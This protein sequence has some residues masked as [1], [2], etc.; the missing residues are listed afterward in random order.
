[1]A[2]MIRDV[3]IRSELSSRACRHRDY[4]SE[5]R[6]MAALAQEMA[7]NP[8][9]MLQKLAETALELC[10]AET[11]GV[12]LLETEEG[13]ELFRWES[14]AGMCAKFR[15]N[16]M[17]RAASPCGLCIDENATQLMYLPDRLFPALLAEPRF[18][19]ALLIPF[20]VQEKP[21]GAL[22]VVS[23]TEGRTFDGENERILRMLAQFA[24]AAWH[25]IA[26]LESIVQ[27][28]IG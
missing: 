10:S 23:H 18:V 2:V 14:L 3:D 15:N 6:S 28:D 5:H 20:H 4:E 11:A 16:T 27:N 12:S 7:V 21:L 26:K 9:N 8:R 25:A 22:W 13:Q 17:P 19:E 1:M 24:S